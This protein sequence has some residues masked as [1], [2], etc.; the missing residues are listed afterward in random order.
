MRCQ[1]ISF[2]PGWIQELV[3]W[4]SST[5]A[6]LVDSVPELVFLTPVYV[7][8]SKYA[9]TFLNV[10]IPHWCCD[11]NQG[12][13]H[14]LDVGQWDLAHSKAHVIDATRKWLEVGS[15]HRQEWKDIGGVPLVT[16]G[17]DLKYLDT[18]YRPND[19]RGNPVARN[20]TS[21]TL[22]VLSIMSAFHSLNHVLPM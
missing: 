14:A 12:I 18:R 15:E 11:L 17:S 16:Q 10:Q 2:Q 1:S 7:K 19:S 22:S 9:L 21:S 4:Y 5:S 3:Y 6:H 20:N 13:C 8:R